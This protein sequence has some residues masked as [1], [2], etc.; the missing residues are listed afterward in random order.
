MVWAFVTTCACFTFKHK[1]LQNVCFT[2]F[3]K[4]TQKFFFFLF[5]FTQPFISSMKD[6]QRI[7]LVC[8]FLTHYLMASETHF[9]F[10]GINKIIQVYN[11]MRVIKSWLRDIIML[12]FLSVVVEI[13][14]SERCSWDADDLDLPVLLWVPY[15]WVFSLL[16]YAGLPGII[17]I[18]C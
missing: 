7:M 4:F 6:K 9:I 12:S 2:H 15:P 17:G 3:Y 8:L 11:G 10:Q 14:F 13:I 18:S 1:G 5:F 16:L